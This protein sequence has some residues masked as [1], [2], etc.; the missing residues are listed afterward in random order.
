MRQYKNYTDEEFITAWKS[1]TSVRQVIK[2][3][4]LK[5]AGG[6]YNNAKQK[7]EKLGLSKDHMTGQGHLKGKTHAYNTRP[8][9]ELLVE[10]SRYQSHKLKLRLIKE[11]LKEH[12]CECCGITEWN[13]QPTPIELDHIDGNHYNNTIENL[14]ILCPNCHAQT[15]T[16]CGKNKSLRSYSLY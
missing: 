3:L 1:S 9:E 10:N 16:Y 2:K 14:R 11:G 5:E 13:G 6:N 12:K 15:E 4:G 8:I 7:A